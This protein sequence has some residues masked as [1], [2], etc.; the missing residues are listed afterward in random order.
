MN[1]LKRWSFV[2][3]MFLGF[4][5]LGMYQMKEN[6][7]TTATPAVSVGRGRTITENLGTSHPVERVLHHCQAY[8]RHDPLT[9]A[10]LPLTDSE[11]ARCHADPL[12]EFGREVT[13][14]LRT[15]TGDDWQAELMGKNS[16]PTTNLQCQ[17][18]GMA[19]DTSN[20]EVGTVAQT[21]DS[22]EDSGT[23]STEITANG[24]WNGGTA[25]W[26]ATYNHTGGTSTYTSQKVISATGTQSSNK[27]GLF[28]ATTAGLMCF[29]AL[30]TKATVNSGDTLTTTWTINF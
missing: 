1:S 26:Q 9:G 12:T 16:A 19:M 27:S 22:I 24:F 21:D 14:N 4:M 25:R 8:Q 20:A 3:A 23:G 13:Y 11:I 5:S 17:Y 10:G 29:E 30:F 2:C 18:L 7:V 6:H 28:T 15:N